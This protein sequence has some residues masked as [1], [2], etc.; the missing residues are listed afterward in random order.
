MRRSR[1]DLVILLLVLLGFI[2]GNIWLVEQGRRRTSGFEFAPNASAFNRGPSGL[3]GLYTLWRKLGHNTRVWRRPWTTLPSAADLFVVATPFSM[4]AES[5]SAEP[6]DLLR[7]VKAGGTLVI[8]GSDPDL[9]AE[10]KL[11]HQSGS[12]LHSTLPPSAPTRLL[13][14]VDAL[15]LSGDRWAGPL[16]PVV[17]HL[18]DQRGPALV[19][20]PMGKGS[21]VALADSGALA[22]AHL[23]EADNALLAA[24]LAGLVDGPIYF[25]EFHHGYQERPTLASYVLRPPLLWA[26]LQVLFALL[27]FFHAAGRRFGPPLPR[28]RAPKHRASAEHIGAMASLY[29]R[30]GAGGAVL[31]RLAEGFRR[32][33]NPHLGLPVNASR[34]QIAEAA[35]RRVGA[36]PGRV[37]SLLA[38]CER[39]VTPR[40]GPKEP[41]LLSA[42]SELETLRRKVLHRGHQASVSR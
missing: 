10:F 13:E 30:A 34:E 7:W 33:V 21:V 1:A 2:A 37:A 11:R 25:D 19:S 28:L 26:T 3:Y 16:E 29:Q 31:Q 27:L 39:Q 9:A 35:A 40:G 24:N 15:S 8:L 20:R 38:R 22:N 5:A 23:A 41:V 36:D 17:I 32:E 4:G 42:A 14:G 6:S 18:H 12:E